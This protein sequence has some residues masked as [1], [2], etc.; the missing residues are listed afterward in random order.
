[1]AIDSEVLEEGGSMTASIKVTNTG[2]LAG[3]E[4]V[5]LYIRDVDSKDPRP[6]KDLRG[7]DRFN[8]KPG[9][10]RSLSFEI[11][12]ELLAYWNIDSQK[13]SAT[14]GMFEIMIGSSSRDEDLTKLEIMVK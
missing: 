9:E 3:D 12:E 10:S 8:L 7:F 13:Y 4:V 11:N 6:L 14:K 2:K 1:M 5:Q